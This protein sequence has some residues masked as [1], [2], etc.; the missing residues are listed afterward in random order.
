MKIPFSFKRLNA[1]M[2]KEFIQ[3]SRDRPTFAMIIGIP[4]LQ[5]ILFGYAINSNPKHLP[6]VIVSA[7]HSVFTRTFI[8]SIKNTDYFLRPMAE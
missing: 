8:Q 5:L 2:L 3:T 1:I 6:T 4:L 7:N